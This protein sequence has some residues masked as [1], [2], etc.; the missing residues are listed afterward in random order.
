[1]ELT[2]ENGNENWDRLDFPWALPTTTTTPRLFQ[3]LSDQT[4]IS[5]LFFI[6]SNPDRGIYRNIFQSSEN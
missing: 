1:M 3:N 4:K 5:L 2:I 6:F